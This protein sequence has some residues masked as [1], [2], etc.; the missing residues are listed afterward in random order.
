MTKLQCFRVREKWLAV[1]SVLAFG[2]TACGGG[3]DADPVGMT[4][5]ALTSTT[6]DPTANDGLNFGNGFLDFQVDLGIDDVTTAGLC[7][8]MVYTALDYFTTGRPV[9]PQD[10]PPTTGTGLRNY[11]RTRH[12]DAHNSV[13]SKWDDFYINPFGWNNDDYFRASIAENGAVREVKALIDAGKP[14]PIALWDG[15]GG[16][17]HEV[18]V[19]GYQLNAFNAAW[20]GFPNMKLVVYDPN[21]PNSKRTFAPDALNQVWVDQGALNRKWVGYVVDTS[22]QAKTPPIINPSADMVVAMRT[23]ADDLRGGNDNLNIEL[24][25]KDG[26]VK[27]FNN[28]NNSVRWLSQALEHVA[29]DVS[30]PYDVVSVKLITTFSGGI[31]GDNWNLD[32]FRVNNLSG[33]LMK[34]RRREESGAPLV[35]LTGDS[36]TQTYTLPSVLLHAPDG[37]F[38]R[39]TEDFYADYKTWDSSRW[40]VMMV[41]STFWHAQN[42]DWSKKRSDTIMNYKT[43]DGSNWTAKL[44]GKTFTHARNGNFAVSHTDTILNYM[45]GASKF[46]MKLR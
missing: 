46:T 23:G 2:A 12:T 3:L 15:G 8:G 1:A 9:P 31:G 14:A 16:G 4:A 42:C 41:G 38:A 44:S 6:F 21:F 26:S 18:L 36:K 43:W 27:P 7:A 40:C 22:Y 5:E 13:S 24:T 45:S 33:D 10:F 37:D 29:L 32:Y 34:T 17:H 20:G 25:M 28:V 39:K 19:I 11:L 30:N 35:R